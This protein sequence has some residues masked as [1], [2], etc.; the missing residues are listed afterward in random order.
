MSKISRRSFLALAVGFAG[1]LFLGAPALG[2]R[3][4]LCK[5]SAVFDQECRHCGAI[6]LGETMA[7]ISANKPGAANHELAA[8]LTPRGQAHARDPNP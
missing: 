5:Q 3:C 2:A 8:S 7:L 1:N 4:P 6:V